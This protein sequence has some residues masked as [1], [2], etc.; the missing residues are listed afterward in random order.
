MNRRQRCFQIFQALK[1]SSL[2]SIRRI[3]DFTTLSKSS[4]HRHQQAMQRRDLH[5]ES[6]LWEIPEGYQWLRL[7]VFATVYI[8]GIQQGVGCEAISRFFHLLRL[9]NVIGVSPTSLRRIEAQMRE[10]AS[11]LLFT[12]ATTVKKPSSEY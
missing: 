5:P 2:S 12:D 1:L 8:F 11:Q 9:Q 4:V 7:L 6:N 3:A 10:L